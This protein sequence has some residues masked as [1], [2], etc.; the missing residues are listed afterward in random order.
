MNRVENIAGD[1]QKPR[2][3]AKCAAVYIPHS[4]ACEDR[5]YF[6]LHTTFSVTVIKFLQRSFSDLVE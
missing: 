6:A 1:L 3:R 4:Q 5:E 2:D